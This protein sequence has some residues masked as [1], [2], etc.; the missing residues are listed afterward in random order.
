MGRGISL[1]IG[2]TL[3][4]VITIIAVG[5]VVALIIAIYKYSLRS[6][7]SAELFRLY[8]KELLLEEK[9]EELGDVN[10][11]IE[12]FKK[13]EKPN[14]EILQNYKVDVA[15]YWYFAPTYDGGERFVFVNDKRIIKK[16]K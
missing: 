12:Q 15:S 14:K 5:L 1:G 4:F 10:Q 2:I 11:V 8:R 7:F 13:N 9:F 3:G 16:K 6:K